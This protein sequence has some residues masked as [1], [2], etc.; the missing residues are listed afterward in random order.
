MRI[1]STVKFSGN[2]EPKGN[3]KAIS[4]LHESYNRQDSIRGRSGG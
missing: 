2:P 4:W 1:V 3:A